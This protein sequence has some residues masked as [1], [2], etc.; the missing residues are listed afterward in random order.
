MTTTK[1]KPWFQSDHFLWGW[2]PVAWQGWAILTFYL[3]L[4]LYGSWV[5]LPH[6]RFE[7]VA[8]ERFLA[9][10]VVLTLSFLS[11]LIIVW[12]TG[13]KPLKAEEDERQKNAKE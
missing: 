9:W 13:G 8:S 1:P 10:L 4:I 12:A 7:E 6:R 2:Y 11:L 3:G 5:L